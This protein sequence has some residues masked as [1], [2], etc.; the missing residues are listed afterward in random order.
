MALAG[1]ALD[2]PRRPLYLR[3][4]RVTAGA[5]VANQAIKLAVRRRRPE[6]EDLPPLIDTMS[7]RSYPSRPR[8]HVVRRGGGAARCPPGRCTRPPPRWPSR[9]S[10]SASTTRA[11]RAAGA[12]L[13]SAV[14][15]L[16]P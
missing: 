9:A 6:L 5:F 2:P 14:A 10:T 15:V 12:A 11:T 13:G 8:D 4:M 7:R 16:A 1:A 3:A